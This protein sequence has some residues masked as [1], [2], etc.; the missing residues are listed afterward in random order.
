MDPQR[1]PEH[2]YLEQSVL[3]VE[4][5]V[6]GRDPEATEVRERCVKKPGVLMSRKKREGR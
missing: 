3:T 2:Y 4:L 5:G 1:V 6:V